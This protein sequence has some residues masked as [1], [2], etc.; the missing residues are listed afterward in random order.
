MGYTGLLAIE[1]EEPDLQQ[2]KTD[3]QTAID[4]LKQWKAESGL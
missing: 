1:R 3:I 2:K 4:R